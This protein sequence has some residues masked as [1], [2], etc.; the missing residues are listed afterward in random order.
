[1]SVETKLKEYQIELSDLGV[2]PYTEGDRI[3]IEVDTANLSAA[4]ASAKIF[5]VQQEMQKEFPGA[6]VIAHPRG[7]KF[8]ILPKS[9][10]DKDVG[11]RIISVETI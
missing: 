8:F 11:G 1:M 7:I 6:R 4:D 2:M 3:L 10:T 9:F 5:E